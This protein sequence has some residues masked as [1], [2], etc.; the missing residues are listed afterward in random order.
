M[1][2]SLVDC[3]KWPSQDV[4]EAQHA[5]LLPPVQA[6]T[7]QQRLAKLQALEDSGVEV[8]PGY[9]NAM[10]HLQNIQR[11]NMEN[12]AFNVPTMVDQSTLPNAN[13]W[14]KIKEKEVPKPKPLDLALDEVVQEECA[15]VIQA[16]SKV[17]RFGMVNHI[18]GYD[19]GGPVEEEIG[20][21]YASL[22][23]LVEA[24]GLDKDAIDRHAEAKE[25]AIVK[26]ASYYA[27][28]R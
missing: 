16:I 26:W 28:N 19:N 27:R 24:W 17:R 10:E 8:W 13:F 21:L 6:R 14:A 25:Q 15:E 7:T 11:A 20:Q 18:T 5:G 1:I 3:Q 9:E 4:L 22:D 23:A 12:S 2:K